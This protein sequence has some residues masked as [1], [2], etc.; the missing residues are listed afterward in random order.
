MERAG[1]RTFT[2]AFFCYGLPWLLTFFAV[3]ACHAFAAQH[4]DVPKPPPDTPPDG[5]VWANDNFD[6]GKNWSKH[7]RVVVA[8]GGVILICSLWILILSVRSRRRLRELHRIPGS[9]ME[10]CLLH[11]FCRTCALTQ[12]AR[13]VDRAVGIMAP[14][15]VPQYQPAGMM[16]A[17]PVP[18]NQLQPVPANQ[19]QPVVQYRQV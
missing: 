19:L 13:H 5:I 10:D 17:Q 15:W 9:R 11:T 8:V 18:A 4:H 1:L 14:R 16:I 12:E 7:N 6:A 2:R 3:V